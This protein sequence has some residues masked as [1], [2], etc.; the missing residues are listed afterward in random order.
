MNKRKE[1]GT[2]GDKQP[3]KITGEYLR[4]LTSA[5]RIRQL[6]ELLLNKCVEAARNGHTTC[7]VYRDDVDDFGTLMFLNWA[8]IK[9]T[10]E[11]EHQFEVEWSSSGGYTNCSGESCDGCRHCYF[12]FDWADVF[13]KSTWKPLVA[14]EEQKKKKQMATHVSED[15]DN[16]DC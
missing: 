11:D 15:D 1:S 13:F 10:I 7:R 12:N 8:S 9:R 16:D 4:S 3:K 5:T 2:D 14:A 6:T